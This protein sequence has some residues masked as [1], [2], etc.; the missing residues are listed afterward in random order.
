[1]DPRDRDAHRSI[2][3]QQHV[4]HLGARGG[5]EHRGERIQ[6]A[7][8]A[9]DQSKSGRCIHPRVGRHHE[10]SRKRAANRDHDAGEHV[11]PRTELLPAVQVQT[12]EDRFQKEREA[13]QR[14]RHPDDRP[15]ELHE[16]WPEQPKFERKHGAGHS[17]HG[18]QNRRPFRPAFREV[19]VLRLASPKPCHLG[20]DHHDGHGH[21]DDGKDDVERE[22]QA[23]LP[24]R[25]KK[26]HVAPTI[27]AAIIRPRRMRDSP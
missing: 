1:M 26:I 14:K 22:R 2:C 20:R 19:Q 15:G 6:L 23:H 10:G 7:D 9:V 8:P 13:F 12:K 24:P 3:R 27:V 17:S 16:C 4:H 21:P 18:E 11:C 5:V 25:V